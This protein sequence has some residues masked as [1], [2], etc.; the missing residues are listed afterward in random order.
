MGQT[1]SCLNIV[2]PSEVPK[3]HGSAIPAEEKQSV[4]LLNILGTD[5]TK[6]K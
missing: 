6:K 5:W 3:Y 1:C 2:L 4:S